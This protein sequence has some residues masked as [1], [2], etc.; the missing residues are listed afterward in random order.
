MPVLKNCI[1]ISKY[2]D[3]HIG[4]RDVKTCTFLSTF[5]SRMDGNGNLKRGLLSMKIYSCLHRYSV[6]MGIHTHCDVL[7]IQH[8]S[9]GE[10]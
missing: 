8:K 10:K 6:N 2:S 7:Y 5:I 9:K 3:N 1:M 4:E